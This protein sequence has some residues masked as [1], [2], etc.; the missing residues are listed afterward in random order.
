[1]K[2]IKQPKLRRSHTIF[3]STNIGA[4]IEQKMCVAWRMENGKKLGAKNASLHVYEIEW[5]NKRNHFARLLELALSAKTYFSTVIF[6]YLMFFSRSDEMEIKILKKLSISVPKPRQEF[7]FHL[8]IAS[9]YNF[10][11]FF[12]LFIFP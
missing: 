3:Y 6:S 4:K 12:I 8:E 10:T 5:K 2:Q 7:F 1:M 11:P 9:P